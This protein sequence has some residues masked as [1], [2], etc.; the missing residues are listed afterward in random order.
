MIKKILVRNPAY[1]LDAEQIL[2]HPW[3]VGEGTED[4]SLEEVPKKIKEYNSKRKL[5]K[6]VNGIIA[7]QRLTKILSLS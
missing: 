3:I 7:A 6:A 5:K 2:K 1:R 4:V